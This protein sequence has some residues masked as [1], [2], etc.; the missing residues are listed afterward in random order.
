MNKIIKKYSHLIKKIHIGHCY[1]TGKPIHDARAHAHCY[2]NII[3]FA[4]KTYYKKSTLLH[5]IAH[6]MR[7]KG[8]YNDGH[9]QK[10][11][12]ILYSIGGNI[13][14]ELAEYYFLERPL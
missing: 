4:N 3:C 11:L 6:L 8:L 7:K 9:D 12:D 14:C 1:I 5:E 2:E 10:W 13:S